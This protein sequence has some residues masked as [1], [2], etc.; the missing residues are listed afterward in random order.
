M[1]WR[2]TMRS[3]RA[4]R[5][6]V[7]L[8]GVAAITVTGASLVS[9]NTGNAARGAAASVRPLGAAATFTSVF[10]SQLGLEGLT[11]DGRGN[12]Y[13]AARGGDPCPVW[14]GLGAGGA[15]GRNCSTARPSSPLA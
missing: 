6:V 2:M 12:L 8:I 4:V 3:K 7:A 10:K 11:G 15:P 5:R 14:R 9:G 1:H 13:S